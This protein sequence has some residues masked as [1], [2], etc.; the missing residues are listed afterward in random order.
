MPPQEAPPAPPPMTPQH[1]PYQFI[2]NPN[3]PARRSGF[4]GSLKQRLLIAFVGLAILLIVAVLVINLLSSGGNGP[5]EEYVSLLQQQTELVR[6]SDIGT[7]KAHGADA[8]GLAITVKYTMESQQ[9]TLIK[10]AKKTGADTS[11]KTLGA[12]KNSQTDSALTTADQT[13]QFDAVFTKTVQDALRKYTQ[14]L[15][16]LNSES[17]RASTKQTLTAYDSQL[18]VLIPE[19]QKTDSGVGQ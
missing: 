17:S 16:K 10:L 9:P 18:E 7:Q 3:K 12:G 14:T 8:K 11:T 19:Q 2:T 5:K 13:N 1:N 6:V 4:V 15:T